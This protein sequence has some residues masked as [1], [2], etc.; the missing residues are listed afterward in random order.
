M[1]G[2]ERRIEKRDH[3][4]Q[5]RAAVG[6]LPGFPFLFLG[7][8]SVAL[9]ECIRKRFGQK[10]PPFRRNDDQSPGREQS[11]IGR[12]TR[13]GQDLLD[14]FAIGA[15]SPSRFGEVCWRE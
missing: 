14:L 3:H 1:R 2:P 12:G 11:V 9:H 8:L 13:G 6:F 10:V 4:G 5:E 15:G 7:R